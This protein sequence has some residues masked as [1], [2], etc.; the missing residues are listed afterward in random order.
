MGNRRTTREGFGGGEFYE[1]FLDYRYANPG[2]DLITRLITT[3]FDDEDG[4][5]RTLTREEILGYLNIIAGAGNETTNRL[6]GWTGIVLGQRPEVRHEVAAT[7][8]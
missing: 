7:A 4:V 2:D 6:I 5:H 1:P 8:R 3:E